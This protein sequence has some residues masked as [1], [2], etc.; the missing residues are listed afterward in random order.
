MLCLRMTLA[1]GGTL[2]TNI[3]TTI[4][5]MYNHLWLNYFEPDATCYC[6]IDRMCKL[7]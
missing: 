1:V 3:A 7:E 4:W 6:I 5:F 2:N